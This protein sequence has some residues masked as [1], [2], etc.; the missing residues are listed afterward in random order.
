MHEE[1]ELLDLVDGQDKVIGTIR[2]SQNPL[3]K[4]G[5]IRAAEL[6]ILNAKGELW[7]PRRTMRKRIAPG[8]LDF[9]AA[10][11]VAS[12]DD[13]QE[14]LHRETEEELNLKLDESK[15]EFLHKFVPDPALPPY[16]RAVYLYRSD[17]TPR[18]NPD[19]FSEAFWI[20][21]DELLR[22]LKGGEPAKQSLTE[23]IQYLVSQGK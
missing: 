22:K 2:R 23:T 9:S 5:Y 18:Y 4:G 17:E 16:F 14:T 13:Y 6:L 15:L 20:K 12:G 3:E 21:P 1:D 19:D 8:G 11:H 7:I 10:G